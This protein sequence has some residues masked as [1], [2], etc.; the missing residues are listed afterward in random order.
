MNFQE[1]YEELIELLA[2]NS[3]AAPQ[4][5]SVAELKRYLNRGNIELTRQGAFNQFLL[6]LQQAERGAFYPPADILEL[7]RVYYNG[8]AL[9]HKSVDFLDAH[10]GG[11]GHQ[12]IKS[13]DG[14][15]YACNW[16]GQEGVPIHWYFENNKIKLYPTPE[17]D[18]A[19]LSVV[20]G[21]LP[22]TVLAGA[23]GITLAGTI[24]LDQNRVDFYYGGSYQNKDQ[25][26]ITNSGRIDFIRSDDT[27]WSA[28]VDHVYEIV[29][30]PD[31][32]SLSTIQKSEKY[33]RFIAAGDTTVIVPGGYT[34]GVGAIALRINGSN[35]APAEWSENSPAYIS[36]T[37]AR[38][39][40]SAAE[41]TVTR[42]DPALSVSILYCQAPTKMTNDTDAPQ[43]DNENYQR[44][45]IH[46]AAHLALSKEGKMSQD[47]QKA[48]IHYDR[49]TEVIE[50]ANRMTKPQ[51]D[52]SPYVA[53]PFRV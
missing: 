12:Q 2:E 7:K 20:R 34:M 10:Y 11:T 28:L 44:G 4:Y 26:R 29:Y 33:I 30:V 35:Q 17:S 37:N 43:I 51:I 14:M 25:W 19:S 8:K 23:T 48:Q 52:I 21:K 32:I 40:D 41:I 27:T 47:L 39:L 53:M 24:P 1:L 6:P 46:Y 38:L 5:W 18:A 50:A 49:F 15:T 36:L 45:M 9:D 31:S 42:S 3:K 16:R 22:G 13:G